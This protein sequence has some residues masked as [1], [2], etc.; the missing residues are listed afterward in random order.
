M[1]A[2]DFALPENMQLTHHGADLEITWKWSRPSLLALAVALYIAWNIA[3]LLGFDSIDLASAINELVRGVITEP[4]PFNLFK[5]MFACAVIWMLYFF[6]A[7]TLNRTRITVSRARV[8]VRHG[9]LPWLG[10]RDVESSTIKQIFTKINLNGNNG[11]SGLLFAPYDLLALGRNDETIKLLSGLSLTREQAAYLEQ[12]L[13]RYLGIKDVPRQSAGANDEATAFEPSGNVNNDQASSAQRPIDTTVLQIQRGTSLIITK[14]WFDSRSIGMIIFAV[15]WT[16]F[17][18]WF[19][20]TWL[21]HMGSRP[22]LPID[23]DPAHAILVIHLSVGIAMLYW[24]IAGLFNRTGLTISRDKISVRHGPVPWRGNGEYLL[25]NLQA[26]KVQRASWGRGKAP[27]VVY[28]HELHATMRDGKNKKLIGGFDTREQA[29]S[30][31]QEI[32]RYLKI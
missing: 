28:K 6:A 20:W 3:S 15:V 23:P 19:T 32:E 18:V 4:F 8:V 11:R 2:D 1:A 9:P 7:Q 30:V 5:P 13:E 29:L 14:R 31:Q 21:T 26:L 27:N 16:T 10:N 12:K 24:S 25:A 17:A 22:L